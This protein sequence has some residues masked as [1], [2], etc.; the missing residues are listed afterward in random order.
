[1]SLYLGLRFHISKKI[2]NLLAEL[3]LYVQTL[4]FMDVCTTTG[5]RYVNES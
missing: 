3:G 5:V 2:G 4:F 1:M